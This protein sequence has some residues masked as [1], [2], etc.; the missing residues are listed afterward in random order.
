MPEK[1]QQ[2]APPQP[3]IYTK[4]PIYTGVSGQCECL[5]FF[6]ESGREQEIE[7]PKTGN[8]GQHSARSREEKRYAEE[9]VQ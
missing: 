2:D 4:R 6:S 7:A 9:P 3:R 1:A 5:A 8:S